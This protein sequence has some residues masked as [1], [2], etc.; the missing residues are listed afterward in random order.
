MTDPAHH[1][2]RNDLLA[3]YQAGLQAVNGRRCVVDY[4]SG[5]AGR[6][7]GQ[8]AMAAI[9]KAA[10]AMAEGALAVFGEQIALGLVITKAGYEADSLQRHSQI[11]LIES[12]HP[13]PD[14]RSL[15]AGQ[16]LIG[17]LH[18]LP[19]DMPVLFLISGGASALV[20]VLPAGIGLGEL[21]TINTTM[22]AAGY[23]IDEINR[24]RKAVSLIKGGRLLNYIGGRP[25][26]NLLLSDVPGNYPGVIGS[27]LLIEAAQEPLPEDLPAGLMALLVRAQQPE[28]P[29]YR[30]SGVE[31][32]IIGDN[33]KARR[34][35]ARLAR[36]KG[37][38]VYC[39]PD[40][41]T[42]DVNEVAER[43]I[44]DLTATGAGIH[45][46]GGE[47]TVR[48]PP[49][50]GRG[51][52]NQQL[53]LLLAGRIKQSDN[54]QILVAATDGSDGPTGDAGG[55]VDG[56]TIIRGE[57]AGLSAQA[58][59]QAADAGAFLEASGD[60]ISTGPTGSNVMDLIIACKT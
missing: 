51:G 34:A 6:P 16:R 43:L 56:Q 28:M 2:V 13:V 52:R 4:F 54:I 7:Q 18:G 1:A 44:T 20:E 10:V 59:L 35:V 53:A 37:Y 57:Q 49:R 12:A 60:L 11:E 22:L 45:I 39:Y 14:A 3:C 9:G 50:A 21:Q 30:P 47:P 31:T 23:A 48:L 15:A 40:L 25:V 5:K 42:G 33:Q 58:C 38:P 32:A 17:F 36:D 24:V 55:L 27:G 26:I 41:L 46:W 29:P 19:D 8:L